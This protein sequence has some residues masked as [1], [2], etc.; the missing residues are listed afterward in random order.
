MLQLAY[1]PTWV[2]FQD[3]LFN[4]KMQAAEKYA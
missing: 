3:L 2:D 4:E 1:V